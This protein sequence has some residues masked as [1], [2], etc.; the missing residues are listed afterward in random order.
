MWC[1][2]EEVGHGTQQGRG[3]GTSQESSCGTSQC[4]HI[5]E[6][7]TDKISDD[8]WVWKETKDSEDVPKFIPFSGNLPGPSSK[9]MNVT[10]LMEY[11]AL[12][13]P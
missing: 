11:L 9:S 6:G 7:D 3:R 13:S 8:E 2:Q 5:T 10:D 1:F 12:L 4:D